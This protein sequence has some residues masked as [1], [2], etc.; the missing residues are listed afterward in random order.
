MHRI[1]T[2][3]NVQSKEPLHRR[4]DDQHNSRVYGKVSGDVCRG[5][6]TSQWAMKQEKSRGE[7][8]LESDI[9]G[10][11]V[12]IG[13]Q[14]HFTL[15]QKKG[16]FRDIKY[17]CS[18]G[19]KSQL[20]ST[21]HVDNF[22]LVKNH[23][24]STA[25][26]YNVTVNA[27]NSVGLSTVQLVVTVYDVIS[28]LNI[29]SPH[30][31]LP[32]DNVT[33]IC[34]PTGNTLAP[35][36]YEWKFGND[37]ASFT[38]TRNRTIHHVFGSTGKFLISV[39]AYNPVWTKSS[40]VYVSVY[41]AVQT[42]CL[43]FSRCAVKERATL[44]DL[45]SL[46]ADSLVNVVAQVTGYDTSR[47]EAFV[48]YPPASDQVEANLSV[49]A[50]NKDE[51]SDIETI[52]QWVKYAVD[53][54]KITVVLTPQSSQ[55]EGSSLI[56]EISLQ[57]VIV[58]PRI[59]PSSAKHVNSVGGRTIGIIIITI[60]A[61]LIIIISIIFGMWYRQRY[62]RLENSYFRLNQDRNVHL[63]L[64]EDDSDDDSPLALARSHDDTKAT[65]NDD[66]DEDDDKLL[67]D[68]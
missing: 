47:F 23:S 59:Q 49:V 36:H 15:R 39:T 62:S 61:V 60:L 28:T 14:V 67:N 45:D 54:H 20:V 26:S 13:R 44:D 37:D 29:I 58:N 27:S 9:E 68:V 12:A 30:A 38:L 50:N 19:D 3:H 24:Y 4:R 10:S 8:T 1:Q 65:N 34:Q 21:L 53:A 43:G 32:T 41:S 35:I 2:H 33:F 31:V 56:E 52:L 16:F 63:T 5:G 66:D 22:P 40:H 46:M 18:F 51:G 11:G 25:G 7:L 55:I 17:V 57:E 6:E 48:V 42:L 64:D